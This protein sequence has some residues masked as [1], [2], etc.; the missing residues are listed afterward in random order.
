MAPGCIVIIIVYIYDAGTLDNDQTKLFYTVMEM[1][2]TLN[3]LVT[4]ALVN[5][6]H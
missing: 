2:W 6:Q 1:N 5:V 4:M 3:I